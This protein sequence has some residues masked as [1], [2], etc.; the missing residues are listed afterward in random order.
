[1]NVDVDLVD[2]AVWGITNH[3]VRVQ[4]AKDDYVDS[5]LDRIHVVATNQVTM[6]FPLNDEVMDEINYAIYHN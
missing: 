1:M 3:H 4:I 5:H 2:I 6:S